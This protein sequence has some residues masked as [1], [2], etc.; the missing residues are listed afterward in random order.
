MSKKQKEMMPTGKREIINGFECFEVII[1]GE[2]VWM[3]CEPEKAYAEQWKG[4]NNF[5]GIDVE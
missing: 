5:L 4:W 1:K 3:P 2:S